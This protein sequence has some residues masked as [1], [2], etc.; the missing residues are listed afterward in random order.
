MGQCK[1][2]G[3]HRENPFSPGNEE[4]KEKR[5]SHSICH[6]F[7]VSAQLQS[8]QK[9]IQYRQ[10]YLQSLSIVNTSVGQND[11]KVNPT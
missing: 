9:A 11:K 3:L 1:L 8:S 10:R 4:K 6:I 2:M 7:P 5:K